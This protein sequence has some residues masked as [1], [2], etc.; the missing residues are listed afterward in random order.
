MFEH[1][2]Q[3]NHFIETFSVESWLEHL[4]QQE[5]VTDEDRVLQAD[6]R[7]DWSMSLTRILH[8]ECSPELEKPA[9]LR[10]SGARA[11]VTQNVNAPRKTVAGGSLVAR[12]AANVAT[13]IPMVNQASSDTQFSRIK[14][15]DMRL[16][17]ITDEICVILECGRIKPAAGFLSFE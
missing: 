8:E 11:K 13:R 3:R 10:S 1:T 14:K 6:I 17:R 4:R 2:E 12:S 9:R 16:Q 5:R 15:Y 7:C